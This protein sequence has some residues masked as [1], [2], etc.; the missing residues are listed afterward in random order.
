MVERRIDLQDAEQQLR[1][2]SAGLL[3]AQEEERERLARALHG[4][5]S[6]RL[7]ALALNAG[8]LEHQLPDSAGGLRD[9][10]S[11]FR[12]VVESL[13]EDLGRLAQQLHPTVLEHLGLANTLRAYCDEFSQLRGLP[14]RY[15]QRGV[16]QDLSSEVA[17]C[18][19]R[20]AQEALANVT[21][22][23]RAKRAS[24][25]LAGAYG[26]IRMAVW[27]AG[28][29]F[30]PG[31]VEPGLGIIAM[32]E[33]ARLVGGTLSIESRPGNGTRVEVSVALPPHER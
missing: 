16:P 2:L 18:L 6:Q 12:H 8:K 29:G 28:V 3:T 13:S 4:D 17:L 20:I 11:G 22:H 24:M 30:D 14:I 27:D 31:V 23:S 7:A 10:I 19:Y 25:A 32:R 9:R 1:T 15:R 5:F 21:L 26:R 33:R